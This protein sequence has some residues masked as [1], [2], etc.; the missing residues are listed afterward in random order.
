MST[1]FPYYIDHALIALAIAGITSLVILFSNE[2]NSRPSFHKS[3]GLAG[4]F[5]GGMFYLGREIAQWEDR[6]VFD[7]PGLIAPL[8]AVTVYAGIVVFVSRNSRTGGR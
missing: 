2:T 1:P 6:K 3:A 8:M 7:W 5:A 4:A